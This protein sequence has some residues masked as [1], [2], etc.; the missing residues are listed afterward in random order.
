MLHHLVPEEVEPGSFEPNLAF[1]EPRTAH[2]SSLSPAIHAALFARARR[3]GPALEAL[4][5]A[6]H[7]DVDDLTGTT[8]GGLHLATM[9]GVWQALVFGFAGVRASSAGLD[10]DPRLPDAWDA[11][12]LNLR[13]HGCPVRIRIEHE[14]LEI[15]A[16][17]AVPVSVTGWLGRRFELHHGV[18]EECTA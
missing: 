4:R 15:D 1:Y 14:R 9:G 18:W 6:A 3:F 10:V 12:E 7:I 8:A 13:F 11:L 5:L 16:D 2:G 17:P